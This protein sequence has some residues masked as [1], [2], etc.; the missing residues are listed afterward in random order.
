MGCNATVIAAFQQG[1]LGFG[2]SDAGWLM[3]W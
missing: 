2:L 1:Q 3:P